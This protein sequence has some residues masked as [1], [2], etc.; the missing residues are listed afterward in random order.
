M[1]AMETASSNDIME[2]LDAYKDDV[3]FNRMQIDTEAGM[4]TIGQ[5]Y[6]D[7]MYKDGKNMWEQKEHKEI[8]E[9][10]K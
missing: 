10:T 2:S 1:M 3:N 8:L 6:Y 7:M 9:R 4:D 5:D